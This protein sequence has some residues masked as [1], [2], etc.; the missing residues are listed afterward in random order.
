MVECFRALRS[1][2]QSFLANNFLL[3]KVSFVEEVLVE[4][5][6]V[7]LEKAFDALLVDY[8]ALKS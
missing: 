5:V 4:D 2:V 3:E 7:R 8:E 1:L 6:E